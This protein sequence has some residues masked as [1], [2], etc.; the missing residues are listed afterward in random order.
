MRN[1]FQKRT[2]FL[3]GAINDELADEIVKQLL[4]LEYE[5]PDEDISLLINSQGGS[6]NAGFAIIDLINFLKCDVR[7]IGIGQCASMAAVLLSCGSK[8]KRYAFPN[9]SI[10]FHQPHLASPTQRQV[11]DIIIEARQ[12]RKVKN[13]MIRLL[14]DN[15]GQPEYVV[16]DIFD[17]DSFFTPKEALSFGAIDR[18]IR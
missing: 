12:A 9:T 7:T 18:I 2:V 11:S 16:E 4:Q 3:T 8:G 5:N 6:V 14:S 10:L 17:R 15:T 13:K 1:L